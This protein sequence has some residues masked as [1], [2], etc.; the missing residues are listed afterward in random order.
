MSQRAHRP[1]FDEPIITFYRGKK[2]ENIHGGERGYSILRIIRARYYQLQ[3]AAPGSYT[4]FLRAQLI[5]R[6]ITLIRVPLAVD[7]PLVT[8]VPSRFL[9]SKS[10]A[11]A[12]LFPPCPT[13]IQPGM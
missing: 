10:K 9:M 8:D 7:D 4:Q 13:L 3:D 2:G 12:A 11:K 6:G 5:A 1:V